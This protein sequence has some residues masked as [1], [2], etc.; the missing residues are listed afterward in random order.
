MHKQNELKFSDRRILGL[1]RAAANAILVLTLIACWSVLTEPVSSIIQMRLQR[2][3][4]ELQ[5]R[6][7]PSDTNINGAARYGDYYEEGT[8]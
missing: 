2:M 5:R 4:E 3:N 1:T 6:I 7:V 8:D